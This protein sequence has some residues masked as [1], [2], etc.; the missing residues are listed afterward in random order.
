MKSRDVELQLSDGTKITW[1]SFGY[2]GSAS[3]EVVFNTA[4]I[5]DF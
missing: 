4:I 2:K 3:G 1:K 5:P